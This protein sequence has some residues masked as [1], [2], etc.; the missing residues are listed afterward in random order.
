MI[1]KFF[2]IESS[3]QQW[4]YKITISF[5]AA[6]IASSNIQIKSSTKRSVNK[7]NNRTG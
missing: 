5:Q 3:I 1:N 7:P 2:S 6:N 4:I